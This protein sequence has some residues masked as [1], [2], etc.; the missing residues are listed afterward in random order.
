MLG[1]GSAFT[2][3]ACTV[4]SAMSASARAALLGEV[5]GPAGLNLSVARSCIG[6]SDYSTHAFSYD[7]GSTPDPTLQRFSIAPDRPAVIP[8]LQELQRERPDLFLFASPWS[9]PAWMKYGGSML[10]GSIRP[11]NLAVYARYIGRYLDAYAAEGVRVQAVTVQN[12]IDADQGGRMPAA[13][14]PQE[15]DSLYMST[16]LGPELARRGGRTRMW[17]LDHN[18]NLAGRVLDQLADPRVNAVVDAVAW[19][20]YVG[21]PTEMT[22]VHDAFSTK[23]AHWTEGGAMVDDP[24]YL[25]GWTKWAQT[26]AGVLNN[27]AQ[28]F[29]TWNVALDEHGRPNIGPFTCGGLVTVRSSD[30]AVVRTGLYYALGHYARVIARGDRILASRAVRP[31]LTCVAAQG[32]EGG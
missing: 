21:A 31:E 27:R 29:T 5:Y 20:G 6:A 7:E 26:I 30:H 22:R 32:R 25:T 28:S 8:V 16:H 19:H 1:F 24:D 13:A 11:E 18:Y 10:G 4:L 9:P 3:G 23:G 15:T 12:E 17:M 2:E 14:W